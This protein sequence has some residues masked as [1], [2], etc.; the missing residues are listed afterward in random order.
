MNYN[1]VTHATCSLT[2]VT[3]KYNDLQV[4]FAI[5]KLSCKASCKTTH[6]FHSD[7]KPC[8]AKNCRVQYPITKIQ[9]LVHNKEDLLQCNFCLT[10]SSP[11]F[12]LLCLGYGFC[13]IVWALLI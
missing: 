6:V 11:F 5:Q 1:F 10:P 7:L 3:Y 8:I 2:F 4:S 9:T 13:N 12:T